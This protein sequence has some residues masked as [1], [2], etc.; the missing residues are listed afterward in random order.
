MSNEPTEF[1]QRIQITKSQT[2]YMPN[3]ILNLTVD[4]I[5]ETQQRF[6]MRIYDPHNKRY[7]VPLPVPVVQEKAATTDYKVVISSKP[8]AILVTRQ[9]TGAT[10]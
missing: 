10:L 4:L 8:F 1:G 2:T 7:E 5:Y 9:S 6:R 3:D